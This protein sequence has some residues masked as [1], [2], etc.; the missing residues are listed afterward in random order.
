VCIDI[1]IQKQTRVRLPAP[2]GDRKVVD[3]AR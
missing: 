2:L 1:A 3:G